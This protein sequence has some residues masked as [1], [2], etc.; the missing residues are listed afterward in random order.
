MPYIV[1]IHDVSDP[2]RFWG[3]AAEGIGSLPQGVTL[4]ATYPRQGGSKA[5]CLWEGESMDAYARL[6]RAPQ[7]T[8]AATSSSR[9]TRSTR[10][11]AVCPGR[12]R[13]AH[14]LLTLARDP[15][16]FRVLSLAI[17]RPPLVRRRMLGWT[18]PP[19]LN[20]QTYTR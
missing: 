3:G 17:P 7:A 5:V 18:E 14:S 11:P 13:P 2:E 16:R 9:W 19:R 12:R 8:R 20:C 1:A 4:H 15:S 6:W 10:V